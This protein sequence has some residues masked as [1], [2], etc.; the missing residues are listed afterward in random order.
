MREYMTGRVGVG[1][2]SKDEGWKDERVY[3]RNG[4][5]GKEK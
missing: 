2:R 5:S 1:R 4:R 3:E